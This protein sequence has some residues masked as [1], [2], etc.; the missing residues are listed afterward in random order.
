MTKTTGRI[1]LAAVLLVLVY[2]GA[3]AMRQGL[4]PPSVVLPDWAVNDLPM[5]IDGWEGE[6]AELAAHWRARRRPQENS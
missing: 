5:S 6:E 4:R 1:L 2:C 3:N